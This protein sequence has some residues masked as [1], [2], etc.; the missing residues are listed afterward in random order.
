MQQFQDITPSNIKITVDV[1]GICELMVK[2]NDDT[3]KRI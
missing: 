2:L 1:V 3:D